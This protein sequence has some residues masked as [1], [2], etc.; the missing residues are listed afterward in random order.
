MR[1]GM[2]G[3]DEKVQEELF[4]LAKDISK[5]L[6]EIYDQAINGGLPA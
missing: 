3:M 4:N 5:E 2:N 1:K 6:G